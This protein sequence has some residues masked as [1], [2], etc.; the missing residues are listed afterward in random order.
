MVFDNGVDS[1][2]ERGEDSLTV[3]DALGLSELVSEGGAIAYDKVRRGATK[4][5]VSR[6]HT[7]WAQSNVSIGRIT[8][9]Y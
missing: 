7:H 4:R 5:A 1:G 2:V 8:V 6:E 3:F 9:E